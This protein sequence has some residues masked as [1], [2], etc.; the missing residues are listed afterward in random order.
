M[1]RPTAMF[2]RNLLAMEAEERCAP[3]RWTAWCCCRGATRRRRGLLM[4]AAS[5]DMPAIMVTGGPMLNGKFRGQDVGSG[6]HVWKF[7]G[8]V[9]AG[10]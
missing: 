10:R 5:V 6:T 3:T 2:Y 9:K 8:G 4:A 1:M 7:E